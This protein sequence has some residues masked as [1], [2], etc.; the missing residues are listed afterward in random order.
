MGKPLTQDE[1][2]PLN[3]YHCCLLTFNKTVTPH[4]PPY[5]CKITRETLKEKGALETN[6]DVAPKANEPDKTHKSVSEEIIGWTPPATLQ[7]DPPKHDI[8]D[9]DG[10]W[11]CQSCN[12]ATCLMTQIMV[13]L[14]E[15]DSATYDNQLFEDNPNLANKQRRYR[16]YCLASFLIEGRL[17]TGVRKKHYDCVSTGISMMYPPFDGKVTGFKSGKKQKRE[18]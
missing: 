3:S 5:R 15:N 4:F 8:R 11:I 17:G 1:T 10:S 12:Q 13:D 16:A 6:R 9:D 18:V 14:D 7:Q 2:D